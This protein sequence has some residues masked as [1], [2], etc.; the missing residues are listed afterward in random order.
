METAIVIIALL[1][2]F[3]GILGCLVPFLP[4]PPLSFA[5]LLLLHFGTAT[6]FNPT[7]IWIVAAIV[8]FVSIADYVFPSAGAR[9]YGASKYGTWGSFIGLFLGL[10]FF[11]PLG[12]IAGPVAGALVGEII[13]GRTIGQARKAAFGTVVSFLI[14]LTIKL[15]LSIYITWKIV[16]A[17]I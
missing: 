1:L 7:F 9:I 5:G 13:S 17:V 12:L 16:A 8:V 11:P 14:L 3:A 2:A 4:G 6:S 15:I 10:F